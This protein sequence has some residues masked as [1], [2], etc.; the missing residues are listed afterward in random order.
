[1]D[2]PRSDRE[3][4]ILGKIAEK[5][6]QLHELYQELDNVEFEKTIT[7]NIQPLIEDKIPEVSDVLD[8]IE[9][10]I[11]NTSKPP[12]NFDKKFRIIYNDEEHAKLISAG[13]YVTVRWGTDKSVPAWSRGRKYD[14]KNARISKIRQLLRAG[15]K[16]VRELSSHTSLAINTVKELLREMDRQG[17][18]TQV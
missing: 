2:G 15:P 1:M 5:E 6:K 10:V 12:I 16:T 18:F 8:V 9:G 11:N 7:L 14:P 3:Y 17:F 4:I 13:G